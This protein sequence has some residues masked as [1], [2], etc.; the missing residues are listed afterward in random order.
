MTITLLL[1]KYGIID[2]SEIDR[3][4]AHFYVNIRCFYSNNISNL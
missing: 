3:S 1:K 4:C 2:V